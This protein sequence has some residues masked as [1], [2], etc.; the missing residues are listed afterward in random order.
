MDLL[1]RGLTPRL[2][3]LA[4]AIAPGSR[5]ADVGSDHG[6]LPLWL[7]ASGRAA[8]CLATEKTPRLLAGV[9]RPPASA[10]WAAL[11]AYRA[12]DGLAAVRPADRIDTIVLAGLGGRAI[13]RLLDAAPWDGPSV[14]RLVLQPRSELAAT[15]AWLSEHGWR[16]ASERLTEERG[17]FHATLA[18]VAG[19]DA[20]LYADAA[21]SREDL[22]TAGPLLARAR[23]PELLRFWRAERDRFT[24]IVAAASSGRSLSR[25]AS[26]LAL[27]SR[28]LAATSPPSE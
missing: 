26:G 11:V 4:D 9:A 27:A 10:P 13:A 24:A 18:A 15:R 3:A 16:L 21:L 25:A 6:L 23:P 1:D 2:A 5:V 22:L 28:I 19:D 17:R 8:Y 7:A 14:G 12:G 20:D